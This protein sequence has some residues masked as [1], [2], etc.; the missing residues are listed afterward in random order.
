MSRVPARNGKRPGAIFLDRDGVINACP[1]ARY[2]THWRQFRFLPGALEALR[3]LR[4]RRKLVVIVSNQS[5]VGRG[6]FSRKRLQAITRAMLETVRRAG[7]NVQ[8]VYYCLH[9]PENR[10][11][12]RKPGTGMLK[13]AARRFS[14]DLSR[15]FVVGDSETD[16]RMGRSGGCRTVLVLSGRH[17]RTTARR[18]SVAPDQTA[19]GLLQAVSWIL[20]QQGD[21]K[22]AQG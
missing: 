14:I 2:V 1:K 11:G 21:S 3:V 8:A 10:C 12:C 19:K 22:E 15:S 20:R 13:K 18:L 16:I 7:G 17:S 4:S 5:G 9:P 6:V